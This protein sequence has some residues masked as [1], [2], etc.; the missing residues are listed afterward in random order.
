[1]SIMYSRIQP[2]A[3]RRNRLSLWFYIKNDQNALVIF[4]VVLASLRLRSH[5]LNLSSAWHGAAPK[6][7]ESK[8]VTPRQRQH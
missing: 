2:F 1:M 5:A 7:R 4:M 3:Q 6:P 8:A